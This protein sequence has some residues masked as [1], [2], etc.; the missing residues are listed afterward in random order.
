MRSR[1]FARYRIENRVACLQKYGRLRSLCIS[2]FFLFCA[3]YSMHTIT[4]ARLL[5]ATYEWCAVC[6]R[7]SAWDAHVN[8]NHCWGS[9]VSALRECFQFGSFYSA[10]FIVRTSIARQTFQQAKGRC[11]PTETH[12][13]WHQAT[14]CTKISIEVIF[15]FNP[16][17]GMSAKCNT[18]RFSIHLVF[19]FDKFEPFRML[20]LKIFT[21]ILSLT[22]FCSF[23]SIKK[24]LFFFCS[25]IY[26]LIANCLQ[27]YC[28]QY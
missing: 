8:R 4:Y 3:P 14:N 5:F 1:Q 2:F 27:I 17:G 16:L 11:A 7:V 23:N 12:L 18:F 19:A 10:L 28:E 24:L 15:H 20:C 21:R 13:L 6:E 22:D 25:W 9:R 26:L